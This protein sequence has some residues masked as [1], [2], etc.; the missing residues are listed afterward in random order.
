MRRSTRNAFTLVELLVV[1]AIIGTLVGLLLPAV[2]AAREAA[3]RSQCTN[4]L[5]Q[6][7][8]ALAIRET[9]TKDLPGYVNKLGIT[10]SEFIARAPWV[11]MTLPQLEQ[12]QAFELWS[13]GQ[14]YDD[15]GRPNPNAVPAL[16]VLVCPSN[17][18]A[19]IGVPNL[20][21]VVNAGWRN[22]WN[23][24]SGP[25]EQESFEN[26]ANGVFFD[27]TR[28]AEL[29]SSVSWKSGTQDVRDASQPNQ[30]VPDISMTI[31]YIQ[32]K[33]DG[34]TKTMMLTES[35]ASLFWAYNTQ[36]DY[37]TTQDA[38]FHFGFN[39]VQP[40]QIVGSAGDNMLRIN[41]S[42]ATPAY[43]DFAGM[44]DLV[45]QPEKSAHTP[46][47]PVPRPGMPS[48]NH[49]GGVNVAFVA[50]QVV[51]ISDQ[52]DPFVYAQLMTSNH[53]SSE[54]GQKSQGY[55]KNAAE[56]ADGSY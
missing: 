25:T 39:W 10:G 43:A 13:T 50:G 1:I 17:P 38:S 19:Q 52:I 56:P 54:L 24:G 4:S 26:P 49:A 51:F 35:L 20:S 2:Q 27:R 29:P 30:D 21:Y 18:P 34:T 31:A 40:D 12:A 45:E 55:E 9:S 15:Q 28:T 42:K 47:N 8:T 48:S 53:K 3:R 32:A 41:G 6:L 23:R 5:K 36:E 46:E 33:G 22:N 16:E 7:S 14:A 44:T 37:N 11:V